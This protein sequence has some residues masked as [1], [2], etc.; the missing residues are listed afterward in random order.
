ME[1]L[2]CDEIEVTNSEFFALD[3]SALSVESARA[4]NDGRVHLNNNL[5]IAQLGLRLST[6]DSSSHRWELGNNTFGGEVA[7][8]L[9]TSRRTTWKIDLDLRGNA[10]DFSRYFIWLR[11]GELDGV[12]VRGADNLLHPESGR[13]RAS[14]YFLSRAWQPERP[15]AEASSVRTFGEFTQLVG[16]LGAVAERPVFD[17]E[18]MRAYRGRLDAAGEQDFVMNTGSSGAG[19]DRSSI[20]PENYDAWRESADYGVWTT[21]IR[22]KMK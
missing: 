1:C 3:G 5:V 9:S 20:G 4:E 10:V 22:E 16:P 19:V 13:R 17:R 18:A 21:A 14:A 7:I 12:D 8:C 2:D 15:A 11:G 6:D